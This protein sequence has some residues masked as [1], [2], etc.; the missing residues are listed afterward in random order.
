MKIAWFHSHLLHAHSGG[1]RF[2]L[3]YSLAL[4]EQF[5][6]EVTMF[7]DFAGPEATEQLR[8]NGMN[9]RELDT[10][11]TNHP[12]YWLTL[13]W[14]LRQKRRMLK[15][16]LEDYDFIISS[17]FPMNWLVADMPQ[18]KIQM[19]YEP[20]AFFYDSV[21][22]KN[23]NLPQRCFFRLAKRAYARSDIAATR[24]MDIVLTVNNTNIPKIEEIYGLTPLVVYAGIDTDIY[25]RVDDGEIT[26][27]RDRHPGSPLLFHS[28]DLTGIKG[29]FPLLEVIRDLS[30]DYPRLKLLV[31]VYVNY[32]QGI[33][34][35]QEKVAKLGLQDHV[36]YLGCLDKQDLPSY[37]SAV[38]FV[39][40]PSIN[41]PACWPLK[42]ALLCGTPIIG[43]KE[44]EEPEDFVNGIRIDVNDRAGAV[45]K[46]SRLFREQARIHV[47]PTELIG[48]Y[49]KKNCVAALNTIIGQIH[50][51]H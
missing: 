5:G 39:C 6:H 49:A 15:R 45:E 21:F 2:V 10:I 1:T 18:P 8:R 3:D 37:Y 51:N 29:T 20:F 30:S 41:Q 48:N 35:L 31:T 13:P 4:Q 46:M 43:G 28:T 47:D 36:E 22:L 44:S 16:E 33:K 19:C 24:K 25:H 11:S 14:R 38:D 50:A 40:Q 32:P 26:R 17:M 42:E 34:M 9:L 12:F 23:F 27:I 7:C